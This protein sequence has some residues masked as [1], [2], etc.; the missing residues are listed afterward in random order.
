MLGGALRTEG[1]VEKR[2]GWWGLTQEQE[3]RKSPRGVHGAG[4][5]LTVVTLGLHPA[6]QGRV[7]QDW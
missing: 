5:K 3:E 4:P 6:I 7:Q 2:L 1:L